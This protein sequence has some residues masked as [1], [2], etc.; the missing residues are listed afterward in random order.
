M[1]RAQNT[2]RRVIACGVL[3]PY[4][5][6]LAREH[7]LCIDATALDAGLHARPNELR[8]LLQEEID[9]ATP[10]A[11]YDAVVLL[12]GLCGRGTA[13]LVARE[14][15][16]VIPR[17]HDCISL[18]LGSTEEYGR[19]FSRHP[20]TFYHSL[21]WIEKKTNPRDRK[22]SE[23]YENLERAGYDRHPDFDR[24]S[25]QYGEENVRH[26]LAFF[27][28]WKHNY[29]RAAYIDLGLPG[30]AEKAQYT[31]RM[32]EALGWQYERLAGDS[33]F[34]L[35]LLAGPWDDPRFFVLP[36]GHRSVS[37]GDDRLF[38][39]VPDTG[40]PNMVE[41]F[42][43]DEA[44]LERSGEFGGAAGIGLGLDAG[45]TF[46][47]AVLYDFTNRRILSK[48]KAPTTYHDLTE[49]IREALSQ[50]PPERLAKARVTALST[51]LATNAIVEGKGYRV[52][53]IVLSPWDWTWEDIQHEPVIRVPGCVSI[54]GEILEPLDEAAAAAAAR[55]LVVDEKCAAI[56]I[57]GYAI[58]RNPVQANR[59]AELTRQFHDVPVLAAH[60]LSGRLNMFQAAQTAV[61]NARL[62]PI[63]QSLLDSVKSALAGFHVSGRLMVLKGDGTS[64]D[65]NI[66][67]A[68]PVETILSGPAAS[69][70]GALLLSGESNALVMDIGGTTTDCAIIEAGSAAVCSDGARIGAW[71][72]SV[73]AIEI[74]TVGLGGDSRLDFDRER[75]IRAGPR[76]NLPICCLASR[77]PSVKKHLCSFPSGR[78]AFSQD[79]SALDILALDGKVVIAPSQEESRLLELLADGPVPL[80]DVATQL[81]VSSPL[82]LPLERL[83]ETGS[84]KRGALTP[85]D[86]LHV[87]GEFVR[88]DAEAARKALEIFAVLFGQTPED[89]LHFAREAVTRRLFDEAI[90]RQLS[91]E[92]RGLK[93]FPDEWRVFFDK[94]FSNH[95][96]GLGVRFA[97]RR[98]IVAI[99]APAEALIR[100]VEKR[101]DCRLIV[102]E[103]AEVAN[104]FGAIGSEV[105]MLE[106]VLIRSGPTGN[107]LLFGHEERIEFA[108]LE[109]ATKKALELARERARSRA[110]A[111]GAPQPEIT[112]V[113]RDS[114]G[115]AA[116]GAGVFIERRVR[117]VARG[118]LQGAENSP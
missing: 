58:T 28:R 35:R 36:P 109:N 113:R 114:I 18:F 77:Y 6:L 61:A 43:D 60:E 53:L 25:R 102:P 67:R 63:I 92:H 70:R 5:A 100:P 85:T 7:D 68:R 45:G 13:N 1:S 24:L 115:R 39:A 46:T 11:G 3:E 107:Y 90:R 54:A 10:Q 106:E 98:P 88:W 16:V 38:E 50:L 37:T 15:P 14:A 81:G 87:T 117:A 84:I 94:A 108:A 32:A 29:T 44:L 66:A 76:R 48:A 69:A 41:K 47:D 104:A 99:G 31:R 82:F 64:V 23:F 73:D 91:W 110:V 27:D 89:T 26:I 111:A 65:E 9:R 20:G 57:A 2:K 105:A 74:T 112:V 78:Y 116:D 40:A 75:K 12:Y 96:S 71:T 56:V 33:D 72:M 86:L 42:D 97:M 83:E 62:L 52:G 55:R 103:H 34:M 21:G 79:A 95:E 4:L 8:A 49:G 118:A 19:Q 30:E 51:T 80:L 22:A 93:G 101:M 17:A 59:V